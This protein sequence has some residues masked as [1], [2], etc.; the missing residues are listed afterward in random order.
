MSAIRLNSCCF[1]ILLFFVTAAHAA[2][3]VAANRLATLAHGINITRWFANP[4]AP[5]FYEHYISPDVFRQLKDA[6]FTYIRVPLAP[7][8][9]QGT[10]GNLNKG[11][12]E[13][14]VAQLAM[15]EQA[16]LGVMMQPQRQQ[17]KL[18]DAPQDRDLFLAF[19]DQLAP[20]LAS[21]DKNLT[22][23]ELLNEPNFQNDRDWD[24]LQ[25]KALAVVRKH[26]PD[27]TVIVTGNHWS[28]VEGLTNTRVLPDKN[29]IYSFHFYEPSFLVAEYRSIAAEDMPAVAALPF[30]ITNQA[31][32]LAAVNLAHNR[33]TQNQI[34]YYCAKSGWTVD[35]V[36]ALIRRAAAWGQTYHVPV[37]NTE[38]GILNT[39]STATRLTWI[40]I[41]RETCDE[42]HMGWGIW[43]YDDGFGFDIHPDKTGQRPLD[44]KILAAL[45]LRSR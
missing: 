13:I 7:S 37:I 19:W 25:S 31:S 23:P 14:L 38:L 33:D 39:R 43:G 16:G 5:E 17:W 42:S 44:P 2:D 10:D 4:H 28:N 12:V 9:F 32:C 45:A 34:K 29:V 36:K 11:T 18:Q 20:L 8:V 15:A 24:D 6:G 40:R 35:K 22:F 30:P 41:V 1:V 3:Q 27:S 26:L 21:L